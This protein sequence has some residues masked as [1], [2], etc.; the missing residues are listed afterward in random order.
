MNSG[1]RY[2]SLKLMNCHLKGLQAE[3]Y[4]SVMRTEQANQSDKGLAVPVAL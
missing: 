2:I 1:K 3:K 4:W